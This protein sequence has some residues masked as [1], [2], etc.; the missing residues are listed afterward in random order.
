M[1]RAATKRATESRYSGRA[2][3]RPRNGNV[4]SPAAAAV[5]AAEALTSRVSKKLT[6]DELDPARSQV[7]DFL[8]V[9]DRRG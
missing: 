5:S 3:R 2:F 4:A 9:R 1:A 7:R 8:D 6:H